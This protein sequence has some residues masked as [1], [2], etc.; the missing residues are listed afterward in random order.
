MG[1]LVDYTVLQFGALF[2]VQIQADQVE[3]GEFHAKVQQGRLSY[4]HLVERIGTKR[5]FVAP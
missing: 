2:A 1:N 3:T 4:D 5:I